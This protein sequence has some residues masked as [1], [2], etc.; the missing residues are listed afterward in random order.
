MDR[1]KEREIARL[2][3]VNESEPF[4]TPPERLNIDE[5]ET[6]HVEDS[7]NEELQDYREILP[8]R[9]KLISLCAPE[10]FL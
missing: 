1:T 4:D 9:E 2:K 3:K 5:S 10:I 8:N 7:N 6:D